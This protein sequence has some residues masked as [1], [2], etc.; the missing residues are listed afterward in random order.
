MRTDA[1]LVGHPHELGDGASFH[2]AHD[3]AAMDGDGDF[4][5]AEIAGRLRGAM[6]GISVSSLPLRKGFVEMRQVS[7]ARLLLWI[8]TL[9][10]VCTDLNT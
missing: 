9:C 7:R 4:A 2:L 5:R 10:A 8:L 3:L 1:E 6:P